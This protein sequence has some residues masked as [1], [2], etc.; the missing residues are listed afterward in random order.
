MTK[1]GGGAPYNKYRCGALGRPMPGPTAERCGYGMMRRKR[2][3]KE[4]QTA[5]VSDLC[6]RRLLGY[7]DS[8]HE[9]ARSYDREFV[10]ETDDREAVLA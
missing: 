3:E 2:E 1:N 8:F 6:R 9:L 7:A 4:L 10:P 5:Q